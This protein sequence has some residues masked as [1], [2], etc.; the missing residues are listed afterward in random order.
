MNRLG[1][2]LARLRRDPATGGLVELCRRT[3]LEGWDHLQQAEAAGHGI[4][5]VT[6]EAN[7]AWRLAARVLAE[8]A[9]P[10]HLLLPDDPETAQRLLAAADGLGL[11]DPVAPDR[12]NE[13]LATGA[14]L[15]R[16]GTAEVGP[17]RDQDAAPDDQA[18]TH[19]SVTV[20][21]AGPRFRICITPG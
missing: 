18:P 5:L 7:G 17:A 14:K 2:L 11:A 8:W 3:T 21:Q 15:L 19:L 1:Q 6:P 9:G 16:V 13:A 20:D 4:L 12:A 10:V